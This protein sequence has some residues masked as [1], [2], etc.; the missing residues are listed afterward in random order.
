M[1]AKPIRR[2]ASVKQTADHIAGSEK[3]V[4]NYI[5]DGLLTAYRIGGL[6][7]L[8]LNEVDAAMI[9]QETAS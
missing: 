2:W 9:R 3:T 8:D 6:L 7:R 5:D 1:P 4:R